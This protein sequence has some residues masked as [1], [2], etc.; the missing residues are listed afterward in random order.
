MIESMGL[1]RSAGIMLAI[2]FAEMV[3]PTIS[4]ATVTTASIC[5]YVSRP[6]CSFFLEGTI[7]PDDVSI[8][9]RSLEKAG[10]NGVLLLF[11]AL[12]GFLWVG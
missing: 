1:L 7:D 8:F 12:P 6:S 11:L 9:K 10:N 3:N 5:T 4:L 2:A